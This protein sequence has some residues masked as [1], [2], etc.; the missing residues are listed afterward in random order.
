MMNKTRKIVIEILFGITALSL[1]A[2]IPCTIWVIDLEAELK[3]LTTLMLTLFLLLPAALCGF[4]GLWL[5]S[6]EKFKL[7]T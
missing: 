7:F 2:Y 4:L 6:G 5:L 3:G 1:L